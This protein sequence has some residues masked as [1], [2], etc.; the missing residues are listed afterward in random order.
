[1][2]GRR[3]LWFLVAVLLIHT[4]IGVWIGFRP[5][6]TL[7]GDRVAIEAGK[8]LF[9]HEWRPGDPLAKGDG[10][11]PVFNAPSCAACH[12]QGG[13][14][15]SGGLEHNVTSYFYFLKDARGVTPRQ[16]VLH[17]RATTP[18]FQETL[19]HLLRSWPPADGFRGRDRG[20]R[21]VILHPP[22][23]Q[24]SQRNTPALFGAGLIDTIPERVILAQTHRKTGRP[25]FVGRALRLA[26]G[27]IGKFGWKAQSGSLADFVRAACANE[28]GLSNPGHAQPASLAQPGYTP[29]GVDL[30]AEQCDQ[31]TAFVASLPRPVQKV[32]NYG[33]A[34]A[35]VKDGEQIFSRV[36]CAA[37]H[38]PNLGGVQGLYSDLLLHRMA[39]E[40]ASRGGS[41]G[42]AALLA[43]SR[44]NTAAPDEWRTP[45]LW[46]VA[47]SAPYM[48]DGRAATLEEAIQLH[49]GQ[50]ADA[51]DRFRKLPGWDQDR[52]IAFLKSLRAP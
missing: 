19:N 7:P 21:R 37:C 8:S 15:G 48:H 4:S 34:R 23:V 27:R 5:R 12:R 33:A 30:T 41:Y 3:P 51:A 2:K 52:L 42:A 22:G 38:T 32:P 31:M 13:L 6:S 17:S 18:A 28:L 45:P 46:G 26:D 47:D 1:M 25:A 24:F 16:G 39:P 44:E 36:G 20:S 40:L 10:L 50:A 29:P 43:N 35:H 9:T 14:G 49:G 11:G